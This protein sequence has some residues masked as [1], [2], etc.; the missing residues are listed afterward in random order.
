V[1]KEI[2]ITARISNLSDLQDQLRGLTVTANLAPNAQLAELLAAARTGITI[3]VRL[4]FV[5]DE[6]RQL[7]N[8]AQNGLRINVNNNGVPAGGNAPIVGN[9]PVAAAPQVLNRAVE[10]AYTVIGDNLIAQARAIAASQLQRIRSFS[11]TTGLTDQPLGEIQKTLRKD[12]ENQAVQARRSQLAAQKLRDL[13]DAEDLKYTKANKKLGLADAFSFNPLREEL[14]QGLDPSRL[15]ASRKAFDIKRL[16]QDKEAAQAVFFSG[17]L[18]GPA[19]AIGGAIG[20]T[21]LGGATGVLA[22]TSIVSATTAAFEK[23]F[24]TLK[25]ASEVA[26]DFEK[27]VAGTVGLLQA[28]TEITRDGK[29]VSPAEQLGE[30]ERI[31]TRFQKTARVALAPLGVGGKEEF[32]LTQAYQEGR[33]GKATEGELKDVLPVLTAVLKPFN[34]GEAKEARELRDIGS[35]Q[36]LSSTTVG[37]TIQALAPDLQNALSFGTPEDIQKAIEPLRGFYQAIKDGNQPLTEIYKAQFQ[38]NTAQADAGESLNKALLPGLKAFNEF[39]SNP[40]ITKNLQNLAA[41]IGN[42]SSTATVVVIKLIEQTGQNNTNTQNLISETIRNNPV[43]KGLGVQNSVALNTFFPGIGDKVNADIEEDNQIGRLQ[44]NAAQL[45]KLKAA[46]GNVGN[47]KNTSPGLQSGLNPLAKFN[48]ILADYGLKPE[49]LD[50]FDSTSIASSGKNPFSQIAAA[51]AGLAGLTRLSKE[52]Q[53]SKRTPLLNLIE[54]GQTS[55]QSEHQKLYD[56]STIG[57]AREANSAAQ[58]DINARLKTQTEISS[59]LAERL[60]TLTKGTEEYNAVS[61]ASAESELKRKQ[62]IAEGTRTVRESI[63]LEIKRNN[64]RAQGFDTFTFSGRN[65][66]DAAGIKSAQANIELLKKRVANGTGNNEEDQAQLRSEQT[67]L[68]GLKRDQE[69][70]PLDVY[71]STL[72]LIEGFTKLKDTMA[73]LDDKTKSLDISYRRTGRAQEDFKDERELRHLNRQENILTAADR[74]SELGGSVQGLPGELQGLVKVIDI[75]KNS[76]EALDKSIADNI[77]RQREINEA[78]KALNGVLGIDQGGSRLAKG[79]SAED[80]FDFSDRLNA[81]QSRL[82]AATLL[83]GLDGLE[84]PF[85]KQF[86]RDR[87]EKQYQS[88]LN[89]NSDLRGS[90]EDADTESEFNI[91]Q[92]KN[93]REKANIPTERLNAQFS[94]LRQ[95]Q[96]FTSQ[97]GDSNPALK[98]F[99]RKTIVDPGVNNIKDQLKDSGFDFSLPSEEEAEDT[100]KKQA[101]KVVN[102]FN[103]TGEKRANESASQYK[104]RQKKDFDE[105][106]KGVKEDL[107]TNSKTLSQ[108]SKTDLVDAI[109]TGASISLNSQ[110]A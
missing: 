19:N 48:N 91:S 46:G 8:I 74:V 18:G 35:G 95:A 57:G 78:Q 7:L 47:L 20:A 13:N 99:L 106:I 69:K 50:K 87:A 66:A 9:A 73:D 71:G 28:T 10:T 11:S 39:I 55:L 24:D 98:A 2:D 79:E 68:A 60:K 63:D 76:F 26:L 36:R 3:D 32:L 4:N 30:Q 54:E 1:A 42:L 43:L 38:L 62:I 105:A 49:D 89:R 96:E 100:R 64:I 45:A 77:T 85:R 110:F 44:T 90:E 65:A 12:S 6:L 80:Q 84:N 97:L 93:R 56:T 86:E 107:A 53:L 83:P 34:L 59:N 103:K 17:L 37:P 82:N 58:Q 81:A 29:P 102:R 75:T 108:L 70:L 5:G 88:A 14:A 31:A 104:D 94:F 21:T 27:S 72:N 22:G 40:S 51:T 67:K 33:R 23:L 15:Q 41:A 101:N 52:Q 61:N 109:S 25:S 92:K 16:T